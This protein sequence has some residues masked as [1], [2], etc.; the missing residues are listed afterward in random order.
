MTAV[1]KT[2]IQCAS[3]AYDVDAST[4]TLDTDIRKQLSKQSL[5]LVAFISSIE[6]ELDVV[7]DLGEAAELKTIRD[8]A[9]KVDE[10]GG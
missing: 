6:D 10:I 3:E 7:I 4:I 8:F 1:E 9:R 5:L 2:I